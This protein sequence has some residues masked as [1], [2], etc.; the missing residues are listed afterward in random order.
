MDMVQFKLNAAEIV[1]DQSKQELIA[2]GTLDS[3]GNWIGRPVFTDASRR[4]ETEEIRY[5]FITQKTR[6]KGVATQQPDGILREVKLLRKTLIR[7]HIL[8]MVN[9]FPV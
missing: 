8:R 6:I 3:L 9:S 7:A 1:I 4:Y 2:K 5:N